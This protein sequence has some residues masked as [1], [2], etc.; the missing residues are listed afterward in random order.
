MSIRV[1]TDSTCDLPAEVIR[2]H[3]IEVIPLIITADSREMRDG[4]DISRRE[5]YRQLPDFPHSPKTAAPGPDV[6]RKTYE[7]LA[8]EGA[9]KI[10]SIHI[11]QK[12]SATIENARQA[13]AD[14]KVVEVMAFDSRQLSLGTGFEVLEAAKA[15]E[16]GRTLPEILDLLDGQIRRTHVC[17][18]LDTLEYMRRGG[19]MN[20][21]ITALGNL[22]QVKPIL[23]MY[24]GEPSAERVRTRGGALRRLRQLIVAH[25]PYDRAAILHTGAIQ[26]AREFM[27]DVEDQMPT[28]EIWMEEINPVLGAHIGPGVVGFAGI[29]S[30][31]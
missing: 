6:F 27:Q 14:T 17:A 28:G 3:R 29:S 12:L 24:D 13:A 7:R 2:E 16:Q 5:F 19:R 11:S 25:A 1:V 20:G 30:E 9:D 31:E 8:T 10:L 21:A 15:A 18:A 4:V 26:R 22:L 23:K